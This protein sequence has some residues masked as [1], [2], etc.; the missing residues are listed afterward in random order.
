MSKPGRRNRPR[1]R[2][3]NV[4]PFAGG[5]TSSSMKKSF[6]TTSETTSIAAEISAVTNTDYE[7][8]N[9][10]RML[11]LPDWV[12]RILPPLITGVAALCGAVAIVTAYLKDIEHLVKSVGDNV[13]GIL[14]SNA[15]L[16][17]NAAV[18]AEQMRELDS[19]VE[20]LREGLEAHRRETGND[21]PKA[22]R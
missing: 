11:R 15:T 7:P 20:Q 13:Q 22:K 1:L 14:Q 17:R 3:S 8:T 21:P 6:G 16:E 19:K 10:Q 18:N 9:P 2:Q 12:P 4:P 5:T